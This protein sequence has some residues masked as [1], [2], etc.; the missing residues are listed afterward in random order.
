MLNL[1]KN[2]IKVA[3]GAGVFEDLTCGMVLVLL[4]KSSFN[5]YTRNK[6]FTFHVNFLF[7]NVIKSLFKNCCR[8]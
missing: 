2:S 1:Q 6:R 4:T 8:C 3:V 5:D 7:L